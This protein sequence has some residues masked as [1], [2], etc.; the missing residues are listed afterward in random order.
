MRNNAAVVLGA[1]VTC[2]ALTRSLQDGLRP[3]LPPARDRG[4]GERLP[5]GRK[6]SHRMDFTVA[7]SAAG[8]RPRCH[9]GLHLR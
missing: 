6:S 5:K 8:T 7:L 3:R 4:R 9:D 1:V 2:G